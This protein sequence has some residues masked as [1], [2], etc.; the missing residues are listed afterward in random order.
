MLNCYHC[1]CVQRLNDRTIRDLHEL[2]ATK[3]GIIAMSGDDMSLVSSER[4]DQMKVEADRPCFTFPFFCEEMRD[5][6]RADAAE[7]TPVFLG[8]VRPM[9]DYNAIDASKNRL[10]HR[11]RP[12]P[13]RSRW[14]RSC[15]FLKPKIALKPFIFNILI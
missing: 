1:P 7:Y 3:I 4:P 12:K 15:N 14:R 2:R 5:A 6:A 10:E 9:K 11:V 13:T 8:V